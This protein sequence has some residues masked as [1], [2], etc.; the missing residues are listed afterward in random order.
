M[1]EIIDKTSQFW[2]SLRKFDYPNVKIF[3]TENAKGSITDVWP[4]FFADELPNSRV[5]I[6]YCSRE[7]VALFIKKVKAEDFS[8]SAKPILEDDIC[9]GA[10]TKSWQSVKI[11]VPH[12]NLLKPAEEQSEELNKVFEAARRLR[13]FL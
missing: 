8:Q 5:E 11:K 2:E 1:T 12:V 6:A 9:M 10:P 4:R 7:H 13:N 3:I